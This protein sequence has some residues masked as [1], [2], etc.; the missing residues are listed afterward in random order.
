MTH[1][2]KIKAIRYENGKYK[3]INEKTVTDEFINLIID[4]LPP[5]KFSTYP[6]NLKDFAIGYS[7][8]E[9]LI[10]KM[11]DIENIKIDGKNVYVTTKF[12]NI[13]QG[14]QGGILKNNTGEKMCCSCMNLLQ[15]GAIL[16]DSAGGIRSD[17]AEITPVK[18][19]LKINATDVIK[20]MDRLTQKAII[21]Q[22]TASVH[23]AQLVY[24]NEYIIREDVS[25]H[26][27]VDK[28]IGAAARRGYDL[29]QSY[30][31]YSG[32]MP[33]DM[34]IK[35]I[36]VGIPILI[37]NAAPAGSGYE[38]AKNGNITLIG[39]VRGNRFNLYTNPERV[40]LNK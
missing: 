36:R 35:V 27:A 4:R 15:G 29:T 17:N 40:N 9:G 26:V 23:V 33:A 39:F 21:W 2:K 24:Q 13:L 38:I 31:L 1:L 3:E 37:S 8:G 16:S 11:E 22:K 5:R 34:V 6:E 25:R 18:S 12:D 14:N 10:K 19:D 32:R 28:V 30:I 20:F 7:L